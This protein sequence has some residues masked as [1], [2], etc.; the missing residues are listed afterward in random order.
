M[1]LGQ[2]SKKVSKT[3]SKK[4]KPGAVVHVCY[5]SYFRRQKDEDQDIRL[6]QEKVWRCYLKIS[7][8]P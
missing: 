4:S 6:A 2:P 7:T 3:L 5:A 8:R 1:V